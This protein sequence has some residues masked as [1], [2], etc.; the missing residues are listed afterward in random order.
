[1]TALVG[2]E[3]LRIGLLEG[4]EERRHQQRQADHA[5]DA[6]EHHER[7]VIAQQI[8]HWTATWRRVREPRGAAR[9]R[10]E[11]TGFATGGGGRPL[12]AAHHMLPDAAPRKPRNSARAGRFRPSRRYAVAAPASMPDGGLV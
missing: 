8:G 5:G 11:S 12:S 2:G 7:E 10:P 3:L 9:I 1:E 6:D 4:D